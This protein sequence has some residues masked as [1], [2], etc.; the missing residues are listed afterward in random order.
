MFTTLLS[1][2]IITILVEPLLWRRLG[3]H[4]DP[5]G[6]ASS[7]RPANGSLATEIEECTRAIQQ[8]PLDASNYLKRGEVYRHH[9]RLDEAIAD[10]NQAIEY[11]SGS[12]YAY[13]LRSFL[14]RGERMSWT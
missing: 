6:A 5:K 10:Y 4:A 11:D 12:A 9:G 2:V 3:G 1:A 13:N 7:P 8:N 14:V